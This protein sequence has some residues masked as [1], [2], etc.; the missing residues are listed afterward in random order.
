MAAIANT[1][2]TMYKA[3]GCSPKVATVLTDDEGLDSCSK[4]AKLDN[5]EVFARARFDHRAELA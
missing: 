2:H 5:K 3:P 4:L 1:M